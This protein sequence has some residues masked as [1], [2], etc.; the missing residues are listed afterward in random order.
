MKIAE[1]V[2]N[3]DQT[4]FSMHVDGTLRFE[5]HLCIPNNDKLKRMILEEVH[6]TAY[7]VHPGNTKTYKDLKETH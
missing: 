3:D 2:K 4:N 7:A 5:N 1:G 6:G